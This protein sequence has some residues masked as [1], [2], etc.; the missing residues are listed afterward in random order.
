MKDLLPDF[1]QSLAVAQAAAVDY[2]S[3]I[4]KDVFD[5][6]RSSLL[7]AVA[8]V[9]MICL[10]VA[11]GSFVSFAIIFHPI[12][13]YSW[14]QQFRETGDRRAKECLIIFVSGI[15]YLVLML[16]FIPVYLK[17]ANW[18]AL[19]SSLAAL[20][21]YILQLGWLWFVTRTATVY[22]NKQEIWEE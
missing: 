8:F 7:D 6:L 9:L 5:E 19:A 10:I 21:G 13:A 14:Y 16:L 11:V 20:L 15:F 1:F 3:K 22:R 17:T 12:I 2:I 18:F 4:G